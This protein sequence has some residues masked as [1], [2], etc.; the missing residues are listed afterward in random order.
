MQFAT[1]LRPLCECYLSSQPW[2]VVLYQLRKTKHTKSPT[3][4]G[5]AHPVAHRS[6]THSQRG[7]WLH[8]RLVGFCKRSPISL[9]R[10]GLHLWRV[11]LSVL[12]KYQYWT[13]GRP[14]MAKKPKAVTPPARSKH[15]ILERQPGES[16]VQWEKTLAAIAQGGAATVTRQSDGSAL[17]EWRAGTT[18]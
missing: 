3:V 16:A 7:T 17:V 14:I 11:S 4:S 15:I 1:S 13:T 8:S 2:Q 6:L 12:Y 9:V 10:Y 5:R 18:P